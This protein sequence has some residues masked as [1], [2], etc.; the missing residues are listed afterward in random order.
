M[1]EG[2]WVICMIYSFE[3]DLRV[4]FRRF[5]CPVCGQKLK[6]KKEVN[7]LNELQKKIY[8]KELYP[9]GIPIDREDG[10]IKLIFTCSNC[11]Y[12]NTTNNQLMIRKKQK[13]LQK[14]ILDENE[15]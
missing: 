2:E 12:Y 9:Y 10:K 5:Y 6:L 4:L 13:K 11:N 8:Y 3:I 1:F 7:K 15:T 14:K